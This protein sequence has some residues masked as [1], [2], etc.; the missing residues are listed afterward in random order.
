MANENKVYVQ[1]TFECS[2]EA[3]FDWLTIPELIVQWFGPEGFTTGEVKSEPIEGGSY[4]IQLEKK[5]DMSF[6]VYGEYLE[7]K[8]PELIRFSYHYD[9]LAGRPPSIVQ[10]SLTEKE[11]EATELSMI[12][13]FEVSTPDF[14][15][16]T[17]AWN[18]MLQRLHDLTS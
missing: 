6:T 5:P 12:Q 2:P 11:R 13:T 16:R 14:S 17:A 3:L 18:F 15:T 7:I 8:K 9:G 10:F 1:R 4:S